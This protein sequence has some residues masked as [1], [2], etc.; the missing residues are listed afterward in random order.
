MNLKIKAF[1]KKINRAKAVQGFRNLVY[2]E[3]KIIKHKL[4]PRTIDID[5]NAY[6]KLC[7]IR[8][9]DGKIPRLN[10]VNNDN[11]DVS[12]IVPCNNVDSYAKECIDSIMNQKTKYKYEVILIND[13]S[14]DN[15]LEIIRQYDNYDNVIIIDKLNDGPGQSR[16]IGIEK[17]RG[18]YIIFVDSDDLVTEYMVEDLL[19]AVTKDD[20][21]LVVANFVNIGGVQA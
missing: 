8:K 19:D 11:F 2:Y 20:Y 6:D 9:F 1:L 17:S 5:N 18:N 12:I 10:I 15:T 16:N 4:K 14:T 3:K 21:D 13:G 7:A